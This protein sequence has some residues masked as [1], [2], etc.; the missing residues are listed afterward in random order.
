MRGSEVE[1]D[2]VDSDCN[3]RDRGPACCCRCCL[4]CDLVEGTAA[5]DKLGKSV[6]DNE[7]AGGGGIEAEA[8]AALLLLLLLALLLL[9]LVEG[10][11]C[12]V[13]A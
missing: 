13:A 12:V 1:V 10:A 9:V 8:A 3:D 7:R 4:C 2:S 11:F 6:G 5:A